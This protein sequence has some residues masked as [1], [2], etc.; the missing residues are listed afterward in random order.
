MELSKK[1]CIPCKGGI[2]PLHGKEITILH[3]QLQEGWKIVDEHHLEKTFSFPD[4]KD[5]MAFV[6][7][8][9][10]LAEQQRH[11][12]DIHISYNKVTLILWTH[13]IGGLSESDFVFAAK[14][15]ET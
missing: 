9:A 15:D 5:A 3:Q 1:T 4:F 2:P 13:K 14:S 12:P 7:K 11:H 10:D 8:L 6:N